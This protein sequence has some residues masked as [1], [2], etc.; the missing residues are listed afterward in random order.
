MFIKLKKKINF[1]N[2]KNI[3]INSLKKVFKK[4]LKKNVKVTSEIFDFANWDSLGNFNI[5]LACENK[6]KI[7]FTA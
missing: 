1:M 2:Q 4:E 5:L 6:F 7:K 3:L